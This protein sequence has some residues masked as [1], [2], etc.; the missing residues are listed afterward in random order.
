MLAGLPTH[1]ITFAHSESQ[2]DRLQIEGWTLFPSKSSASRATSLD[3]AIYFA[4]IHDT[5]HANM[6]TQSTFNQN[7]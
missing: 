4:A 1:L 2:I 7:N 3:D 5:Q 6:P